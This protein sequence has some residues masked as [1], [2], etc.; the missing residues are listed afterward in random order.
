METVRNIEV[1]LPRGSTG[2]VNA[3]N[4]DEFILSESD[5]DKRFEREIPPGRR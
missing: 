2:G 4:N 5:E 3:K 1:S